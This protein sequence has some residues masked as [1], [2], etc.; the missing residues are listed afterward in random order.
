MSVTVPG[1]GIGTTSLTNTN[2][3]YYDPS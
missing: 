2:K 1:S 3:L